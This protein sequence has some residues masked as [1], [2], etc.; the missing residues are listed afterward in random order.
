MG[1]AAP[2][3]QPKADPRITVTL[4]SQDHLALSAMAER[5]DVSLS[6]LTRQAISEFLSNH[7]KEDLQLPLNLQKKASHQ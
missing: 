2:K 4:S 1:N 6:W 3:L 5:C 7:A